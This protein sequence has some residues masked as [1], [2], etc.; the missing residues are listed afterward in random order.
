MIRYSLVFL[1]LSVIRCDKVQNDVH[2]PINSTLYCK[3]GFNKIQPPNFH[4]IE[5]AGYTGFNSTHSWFREKN[6][7]CTAT[8]KDI[9]R[10]AR[11]C[12]N[13]QSHVSISVMNAP[14]KYG[15]DRYGNVLKELQVYG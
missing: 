8:I 7:L 15:T 3:V 12:W 10:S 11:S 6:F 14:A 1:L 9:K 2:I 4:C 13:Y 5:H